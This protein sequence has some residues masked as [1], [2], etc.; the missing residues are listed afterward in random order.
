ME[1]YEVYKPN[2]PKGFFLD[3]RTKILFMIFITT[4]M[5]V[6][7]KDILVS[8]ISAI[9]A[10]ALLLLSN[11]QVK[12]AFI[13][14]GLFTL[15]IMAHFTKDMYTLPT[16]I[17]TI[18]VLLN[19]LILRLFPIFMLGYYVVMSTK[20]SEFIAAM[21]KWKIPN[22]FI[23]PTAVAFRFIPTL[24]EEHNSIKTAMKMRGIS[25]KNKKAWKNPSLYLEYVTIPL[26]VSIAKIGD[27]LSAAAISRGLGAL[28]K[29]TTVVK[30]K[31]TIYDLLI[32]LF[33]IAFTG[34]F[35]YRRG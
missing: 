19:A 35:L 28:K 26:I 2:K 20:T 14:G 11:K 24:K 12:I 21:V 34:L 13:Y 25:F 4:I 6:G 31:F 3:P 7:Y 15:A 33:S 22:A 10:I 17:N 32:L 23:I 27:E 18:S 30:V 8:L 5:S 29:R 1:E 9:V 16:L